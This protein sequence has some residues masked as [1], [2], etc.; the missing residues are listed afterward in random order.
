MFSN[1]AILYN[2]GSF[3]HMYSKNESLQSSTITSEEELVMQNIIG[4]IIS[5][6]VS[7]SSYSRHKLIRETLYI[8]Y[9]LSAVAEV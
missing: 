3:I 9:F 5:H 1:V 4:V 2:F 7:S 8:Y 6:S